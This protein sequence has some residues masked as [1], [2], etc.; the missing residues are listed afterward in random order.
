VRRSLVASGGED[1]L[2]RM[3][4]ILE[5]TDQEV[6]SLFSESSLDTY[7]GDVGKDPLP[8]GEWQKVSAKD[9]YAAIIAGDLYDQRAVPALLKAMARPPIPSYFVDSA[10][11]PVQ[12][13]AIL[14]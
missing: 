10:P 13:N 7:K 2:K 4:Q 5:G 14:D 6:N 8:Q 3:I 12:H 11:G 1:V 9:Y